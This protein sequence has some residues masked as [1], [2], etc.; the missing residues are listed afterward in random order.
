MPLSRRTNQSQETWL[1]IGGKPVSPLTHLND[2]RSR[3]GTLVIGVPRL[4]LDDPDDLAE[5]L[6]LVREVSV[7][8]V[9]CVRWAVHG[10][11]L[12]VSLVCL[13]EEGDSGSGPVRDGDDWLC[14]PGRSPVTVSEVAWD[15]SAVTPG[16]HLQVEVAADVWKPLG[17]Q[18]VRP[19]CATCPNHSGCRIRHVARPVWR[20]APM[21][22]LELVRLGER[23]RIHWRPGAVAERG[24]ICRV[25]GRVVSVDPIG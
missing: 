1:Y 15:E 25:L 4:M 10:G 14:V 7:I 17:F 19:T 2:R 20:S 8:R 5:D 3:D 16:P 6:Q 13:G 18:A 12:A 9:S 21:D 24:D 23:Q 11:T 22:P